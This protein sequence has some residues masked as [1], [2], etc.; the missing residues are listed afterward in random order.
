M[1]HLLFELLR[2][3]DPV[4]RYHEQAVLVV[5]TALLW[6]NVH[7]LAQVSRPYEL[8]CDVNDSAGILTWPFSAEDVSLDGFSEFGRFFSQLCRSLISWSTSWPMFGSRR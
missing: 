8:L 2:L 6:Q 7:M 4:Q 1:R 5:Q 3:Y